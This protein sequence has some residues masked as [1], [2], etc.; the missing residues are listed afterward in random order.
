MA[1]RGYE[2]AEQ[3]RFSTAPLA[4]Q[5]RLAQAKLKPVVRS[6]W[7]SWSTTV[8]VHVDLTGARGIGNSGVMVD[9]STVGCRLKWTAGVSDAGV[10]FGPGNKNNS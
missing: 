8:L 7:V 1:T 5:A 9:V 10:G 4:L 3:G 6:I 2:Q